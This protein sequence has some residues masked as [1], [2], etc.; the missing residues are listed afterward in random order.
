HRNMQWNVRSATQV[1]GAYRDD[2]AETSRRG[3][4]DE[5]LAA[6]SDRVV[7]V[8]DDL[9]HA[10]IHN[11]ANDHNVLVTGDRVTGLLDF[12]DAVWAPV[13]N[14]VAVG[15]A[16]AMLD[17]D[18]PHTVADAVVSGF[19]QQRPLSPA[20]RAVLPDLIRVRLATSV[21]ISAHQQRLD[22]D[23]PYLRVSE[24]PAWR[25]LA[26]LSERR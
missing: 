7:P 26:R 1:L 5:T 14:E 15:C 18:D 6:F 9:P 13:V 16:Y 2:I 12:G 25:L 8:L 10:V 23:D 21:A 19:G 22:P 3:L 24:E 4:V 20:E 17:A 11:D